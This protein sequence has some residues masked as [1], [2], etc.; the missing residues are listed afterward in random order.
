M[1]EAIAVTLQNE[2]AAHSFDELTGERLLACPPMLDRAIAS[3]EA[4]HIWRRL[5]WPRRLKC[6][7]R[8]IPR[9]W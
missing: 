4:N 1:I 5:R 7:P 8:R 9:A 2:I 6:R 3:W